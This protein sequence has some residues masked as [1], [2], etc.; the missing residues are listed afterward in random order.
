[1]YYLLTYNTFCMLCHLITQVGCERKF[2]SQ[3]QETK[4]EA[5]DHA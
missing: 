4:I 5:S 2:T 3:C 1:M